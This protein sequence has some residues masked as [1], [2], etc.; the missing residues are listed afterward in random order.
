[1]DL[2]PLGVSVVIPIDVTDPDTGDPA[3]T[4]PDPTLTL[5]H[6]DG[7]PESLAITDHPATGSYL[8]EIPAAT[9]DAAGTWRVLPVVT[10]ANASTDFEVFTVFDPDTYPRLVSFADAK[11]VVKAL[12]DQ[13]DPLLDRMIGWASARILMEVQAYRQSF[14]QVVNVRGGDCFF[15]LSHTPVRSI[16]SITALG[17]YTY[18]PPAVSTLVPTIPNAGHVEATSGGLWG[19]YEVVYEAGTD[20]VPPG[21]DGACLALLQHWWGQI[22][23]RRSQSYGGGPAGAMPDFRGLPN[24]VRNLLDTVSA[25]W[26][27]A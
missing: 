10:G 21:V 25:P 7:T 17:S 6:P 2:Y 9:L 3:D 14:T 11:V 19:T 12:G 4:T 24:T 5:I 13:D 8:W 1:V 16:T 20:E 18:S 27:M 26:G 15:K 22:V 23:S